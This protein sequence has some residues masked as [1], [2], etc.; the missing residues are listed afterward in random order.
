MVMSNTISK[1]SSG[2]RLSF[3]KLF[4]EKQFQIIIPIIQRDYAQGRASS[5]NVREMFLNALYQYLEENKPNRDLDFV[6]GSIIESKTSEFVPLDGQQRLTTLFLLHWYLAIHA[7]K[8]D[9]FKTSLSVNNKSKFTYQTRTSSIEFCDALVVNEVDLDNLL[10]SDSVL[11]NSLSKTI[12]NQ[13]WYY[14]SWKNDPTVE[15]MLTMLDAIHCKFYGKPEFYERLLNTEH[16]IITFLFLNLQEF[17]LTDDLYIKM[18]SRGKPLSAFENFKANFEQHLSTIKLPAEKRYELNYKNKN[19]SSNLKDYFAY[20][21]DINWANL[22]WNYR[23]L[24]S[25]PENTD[26][27]DNNSDDEIMNFIRIVFSNQYAGDCKNEKDENLEYLIGTSIARKRK[28]YSDVF[29]FHKFIELNAINADSVFYLVDS[30][31]KLENGNEKIKIWLQDNFYFDEERIFQDVLKNNLSSFQNRVQFHAYLKYLIKYGTEP[32]NLTQWM[33]VIHNLTSNTAIDG[34]EEVARAIKS[35]NELLNNQKDIL[36]SLKDRN[37]KVDFFLGRQVY[38]EKVKAFLVTKSEQ[39]KD[40][41]IQAEKQPTLLGQI[42]FILEFSGILKFFDDNQN[43]DWNED[44]NAKFFDAFIEYSRK[45]DAFLTF[46]GSD[47]N[48]EY[49][50]ERAVLTKGDYLLAASADRYNFLSTSKFPRD[51]S[52]KR[53]LRLPPEDAKEKDIE[54]WRDRRSYVKNVFDDPLFNPDATEQSLIKIAKQTVNDWRNLFIKN[55]EL[56]R[57]CEQGFI[58]FLS[59][60][61]IILFKHSQLNHRHRELYSYN[62]FL[63]LP[64]I[65]PYKSST[66]RESNVFKHI[67]H[68]EVRSTEDYSYILFSDFCLNRIYYSMEVY[69][70]KTSEIFKHPYQIRFVKTKGNNDISAYS[71]EISEQLKMLKFFWHEDADWRGYWITLKTEKDAINV[72]QEI[73]KSFLQWI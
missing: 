10:P 21:I 52:W 71:S 3:Y 51:Y 6:Y 60:D 24:Y 25:H 50:W 22:F 66:I 11:Q 30:L 48:N 44:D 38:E 28:D 35:I 7:K 15:S 72:I 31:D 14:L 19:Q 58:R 33:R 61:D 53:L 64:E 70:D 12:K 9:T 39:W 26:E 57:Y 43:C 29:S 32:D 65:F 17:S 59:P 55:A 42:G 13:P 45:S 49:L 37:L 2:E 47:K 62:M 46:I 73:Q 54:Y 36:S 63:N 18:N 1:I 67:E 40:V 5:H 41:I 69:Y 56:I 4:A 16:P 27:S 68:I 23:N 34:A 8:I 20:K